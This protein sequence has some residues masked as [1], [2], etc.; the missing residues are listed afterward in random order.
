MDE[1]HMSD[2]GA[3]D[4][5]AGQAMEATKRPKQSFVLHFRGILQ[6]LAIKAS[7]LPSLQAQYKV[8]THLLLF[9]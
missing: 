1:K 5:T 3:E 9:G 4:A 8:I 2:G 6:G 7:L